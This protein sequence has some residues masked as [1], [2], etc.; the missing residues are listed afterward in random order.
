MRPAAPLPASAQKDT[1]EPAAWRDRWPRGKRKRP[2]LPW[3][4]PRVGSIAAQEDEEAESQVPGPERPPRLCL[5]V[6]ERQQG[7]T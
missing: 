1:G 2:P 4:H 6:E 5:G 7:G 3:P